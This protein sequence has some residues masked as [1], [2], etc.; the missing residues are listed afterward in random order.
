MLKNT[1]ITNTTPR[2][3]QST[4]ERTP[5][6]L[7]LISRPCWR[8]HRHS[9]LDRE[10][11]TRCHTGGTFWKS[12]APE[13]AI[14]RCHALE[15]AAELPRD[16]QGMMLDAGMLLVAMHCRSW[17]PEKPFTK[18]AQCRR[19]HTLQKLSTEESSALYTLTEWQGRSH[20]QSRSLS[21]KDTGTRKKNI[22]F[23]NISPAPSID[24]A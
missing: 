3:R 16:Y 21:R 13:K 15:L 24:K 17:A 11:S 12:G 10:K 18:G 23:S 5:L 9:T 2:L 7:G 14:G 8:E 1:D 22:L 19:R 20:A 4:Q 6:F